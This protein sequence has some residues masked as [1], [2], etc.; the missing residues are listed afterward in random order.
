MSTVERTN[1]QRAERRLQ[2]RWPIRFAGELRQKPLIGQIVDVTSRGLAFLYH[3]G[4]R[5]PQPDQLITTSFGVPHFNSQ[6][7]FD[8]VIA[9]RVGRVCRVDSL[10]DK[11]NRVAIEFTEPLFFR[12]GEQ[13]ISDAEVRKRLEA[14]ARSLVRGKRQAITRGQTPAETASTAAAEKKPASRPRKS[15]NPQE[16]NTCSV[17][18]ATW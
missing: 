15:A 3:P 1:E 9:N 6:G 17:W 10:S 11:V 2:Y 12:P 18:P 4:E 8:T 16:Q 7:S 13:D 5:C 14:A